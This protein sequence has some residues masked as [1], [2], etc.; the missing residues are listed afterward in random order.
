MQNGTPLT[1]LSLKTSLGDQ[2]DMPHGSFRYSKMGEDPISVHFGEDLSGISQQRCKRGSTNRNNV[3][4]L[5][6]LLKGSKDSP[7]ATTERVSEA[8]E[9]K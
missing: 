2:D 8:A 9:E 1:R 5:P 7:D 4:D 6:K 3:L